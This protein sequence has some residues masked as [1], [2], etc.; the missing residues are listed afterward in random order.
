[1]YRVIVLGTERAEFGVLADAVHE[2][3]RFP[4]AALFDLSGTDD[5]H[6]YVRG[7]TTEALAVLDGQLVLN[8]TRFS[9]DDGR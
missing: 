5:H 9:I 8:D 1:M 3:T 2:V 6:R 7:V 4:A